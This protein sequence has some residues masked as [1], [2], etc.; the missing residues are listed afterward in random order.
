MT[1]TR[2][3]QTRKK[4]RGGDLPNWNLND[5]YRG[6]KSPKLK[7]DIAWALRQSKKFRKAFEGR[8]KGLDGG[9]LARA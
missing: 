9:S 3:R 7:A 2:T 4:S 1:K 8:L 5:L 6:P